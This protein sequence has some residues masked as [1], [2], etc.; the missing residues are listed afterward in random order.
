M[1]KKYEGEDLYFDYGTQA[2]KPLTA[3]EEKR[4]KKLQEQMLKKQRE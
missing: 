4:H 3:K 2:E 1:S